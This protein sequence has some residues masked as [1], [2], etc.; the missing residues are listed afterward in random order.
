MRRVRAVTLLVVLA[1]PGGGGGEMQ[2]ETSASPAPTA[3]QERGGE[4]GAVED[5]VPSEDLPADSEVAFPI[6][7]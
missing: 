5:F 3:A 7:I 2:E 4:Q 6:D 1:V